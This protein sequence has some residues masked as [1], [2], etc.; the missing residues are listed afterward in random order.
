MVAAKKGGTGKGG[1]KQAP[2][3][4][5]PPAKARAPTTAAAAAAGDGAALTTRRSLRRNGAGVGVELDAIA[6]LNAANAADAKARESLTASKTTNTAKT[7][8]GNA[9][10]TATNT[11]TQDRGG[12]IGGGAAKG[13]STTTVEGET[14]TIER[15]ARGVTE[16]TT[17]HAT[18][19]HGSDMDTEAAMHLEEAAT[20][21][22]K[23][24]NVEE[25]AEAAYD[26]KRAATVLAWEAEALD[27][28]VIGDGHS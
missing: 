14:G 18:D 7:T 15:G 4:G 17:G 8:A 5:K 19:N 28:M 11:I 3:K 24:G 10:A 2:A 23:R 13:A 25:E 12:T 26:S 27:R 9:A 6:G 22:P 21:P 1:I 16:E 20:P